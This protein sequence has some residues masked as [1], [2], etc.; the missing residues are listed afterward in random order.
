MYAVCWTF[1]ILKSATFFTS[2]RFCFLKNAKVDILLYYAC[3]MYNGAA[4][5]IHKNE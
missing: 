5:F 3:S 1:S 2:F 4:Y